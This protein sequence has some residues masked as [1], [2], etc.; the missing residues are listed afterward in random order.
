ME[1]S[2]KLFNIVYREWDGRSKTDNAGDFATALR[3]L[4]NAD[5]DLSSMPQVN[6]AKADLMYRWLD[7]FDVVMDQWRILMKSKSPGSL[8]EVN[9]K[10]PV[11]DQGLAPAPKRSRTADYGS[12]V[13]VVM[14]E[15]IKMAGPMG[16]PKQ[17][18]Q[19]TKAVLDAYEE[20]NDA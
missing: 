5:V 2:T 7:E 16:D 12:L 11:L 13:H 17:I 4:R 8:A 6:G 10:T 18:A 3:E 19:K 9:P 1:I 14:A 20:L 15:Y